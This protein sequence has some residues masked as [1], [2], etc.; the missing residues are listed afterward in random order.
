MVGGKVLVVGLARNV[1]VDFKNNF[2]VLSCALSVFDN[3]NYYVVESDSSDNTLEIFHSIRLKSPNFDFVSLGDLS[4]QLPNRLDRIVRCRNAYL[5]YF[6]KRRDQF[7]YLIVADLDGVNEGLSA[8]AL[9]SV[10][11]QGVEWDGVFANQSSFY[12]DVWALRHDA[13][14]PGDCWQN[15]RFLKG[16]GHS[17][18]RAVW[19][20]VF[21]K[22]IHLTK[23]FP[24][25]SVRSAFGGL[26]ILKASS[27]EIE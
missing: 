24:W 4:D 17:E 8:S 23:H 6:F 20:A 1:A 18:E 2:D 12:Y 22:M 13:W 5:D 11:S 14:C 7:D 9:S 16:I 21:S 19:E 3:V 10:W 25:I 26:G 15:Y 27:R